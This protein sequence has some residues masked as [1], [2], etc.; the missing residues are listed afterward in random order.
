MWVSEFFSNF[1][2]HFVSADGCATGVVL[3]VKTLIFSRRA[4]GRRMG[5]DVISTISKYNV[6]EGGMCAGWQ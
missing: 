1:A 6:P 5:W 2:A 3:V 4:R